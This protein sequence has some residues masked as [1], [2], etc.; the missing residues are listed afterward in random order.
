[1]IEVNAV[2]IGRKIFYDSVT[3]EVIIDSGQYDNALK[4]KSIEELIETYAVLSERNRKTFDV[5]ELEYDQYAQDF[6]ESN[7]YRVSPET[8]QLEFSYPDSNEPEVEQPYIVPLSE[9]IANNTAYLLDVDFR[10]LM[11]ELGM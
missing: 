5:I 2:R 8:K 10:V 6:A 1:M 3:G 7:G 9:Q 11:I 4:E